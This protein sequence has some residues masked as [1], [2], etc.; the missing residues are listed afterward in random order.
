MDALKCSMTLKLR[1]SRN[2]TQPVYMQVIEDFDAFVKPPLRTITV[3]F[4]N[5]DY[6]FLD[7]E[8]PET[9]FIQSGQA[10]TLPT[11]TGTYEDSDGNIFEPVS[12][13][14]GAFGETIGPIEHSTFC[15]LIMR[16]IDNE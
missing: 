2:S 3:R 4:I 8:L 16:K 14:L 13:S 5:V 7:V 9:M 1:V 12:W 11:I 15:N 10:I 6:S